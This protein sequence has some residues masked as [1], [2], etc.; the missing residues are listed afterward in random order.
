MGR[1]NKDF[2]TMQSL[3][4]DWYGPERAGYEITA[5]CPKAVSLGDEA[6][7]ILEK[8]L[9]KDV[10][11]AMKLREQWEKI[12]G[13]QIAKVSNPLKI[14]NSIVYVEVSHSAWLRELRGPV[15][16]QLIRKINIEFGDGACLDIKF[17]PGGR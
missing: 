7:K 13:A 17:V 9:S 4:R 1:M 14:Q 3:L 16:K 6:E 2:Y 8:T 15:K 5:Y 10:I 12:A 11:N